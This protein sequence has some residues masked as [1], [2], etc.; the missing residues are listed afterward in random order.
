[1]TM[2]TQQHKEAVSGAIAGFAATIALHP[3]DVIKTRLREDTS[4]LEI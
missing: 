2:M 1:M 4:K 3:L